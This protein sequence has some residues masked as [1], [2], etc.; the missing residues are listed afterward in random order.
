MTD[1]PW[2]GAARQLSLGAIECAAGRLGCEPAALRA[3][4]AVEASGAWFRP[5]GSL[6]RRFEPHKMPGAGGS[7]RDP[8]ARPRGRVPRRLP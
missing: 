4:I 2:K 7:W 6:P 5:D 3:V 1:L 8:V